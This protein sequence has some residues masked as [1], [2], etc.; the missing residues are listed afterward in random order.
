MKKFKTILPYIALAAAIII[1]YYV[2]YSGAID[3]SEMP[4]YVAMS[5][6]EVK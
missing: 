3:V 2:A 6:A 1:Q 4:R 5:A